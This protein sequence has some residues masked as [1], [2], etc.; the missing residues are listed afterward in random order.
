MSSVAERERAG[1]ISALARCVGDPAAFLS[2]TWGRR[3]IVHPGVDPRGFED[4]LRL[5]DVDELL[6]T[7]SLRTPAFRLVQAGRQIPESAY[8]RSGTT[9]SKPVGGM[10]DPARIAELFAGGAT[11]V[12]QGLHRYRE[13][14]ARFARA[15]ELELGHRC[16]VNAY[17]T[18]A[19][20]QGLPLHD[21]PHD[22]LVL[23][24]FGE[25]AWEIHAAPGEAERAPIRTTVRPGDA[26]YMPEGTP[27]A[28]AAQETISGHLTVGVHVATWREVVSRAWAAVQGPAGLD[29]PVPAGWPS[30][31]DRFGRELRARLERARATLAEADAARLAEDHAVAFLS[32]RPPL[33]SGLLVDLQGLERI[34]DGTVLER[35]P[36]SVCELRTRGDRLLV[37]LGDRRLEMPLWLERAMRLLASERR[38]VVG[39]LAG[40]VPDRGSRLVLVRRLVR[41]G[42]LRPV[43]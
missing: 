38:V 8:T 18:P 21:D 35:R 26:I 5:E 29:E 14:V 3:P 40:E 4:L 23:Q 9:G 43:G 7:T 27:H 36:G 30:D 32:T 25:K 12:L 20:S 34:D 37:L 17:V 31:L 39:D 16:Q 2:Q 19:G 6:T 22:V 41:E 28:A 13:P 42:L 24:A 11:I 10:A 15:L 1:T 33:L